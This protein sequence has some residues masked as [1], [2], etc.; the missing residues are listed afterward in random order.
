RNVFLDIEAEVDDEDE[1]EDDER[2]G[3]EIEGFIDHSFP[4]D[5]VDTERMDDSKRHRELD[6]RREV[7]A[8]LDAEKQAEILRQRY[9]NRRSG[10]G[11][12]NSTVI[13]KRLL[14]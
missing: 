10:R 11:R 3:E 13:P 14:L 6:R 1:G 7:E 9:G 2:D 5:I 12:G 4:D 8:G